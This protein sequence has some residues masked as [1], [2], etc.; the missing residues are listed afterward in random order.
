MINV[1]MQMINKE[2]L[3]YISDV[4]GFGHCMNTTGRINKIHD[5]FQK[6]EGA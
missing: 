3:R 2:K 1:T 6:I 5:G 4:N